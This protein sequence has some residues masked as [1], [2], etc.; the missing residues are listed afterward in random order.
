MKITKI[1]TYVVNMPLRLDGDVPHV[2]GRARTALEMLLVRI[3]ADEGIT[4]WGEG[5]GHRIGSATRAAIDT[6]KA[7]GARAKGA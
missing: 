2:G 7:S 4:G 5:F 6:I 1:T 3:D